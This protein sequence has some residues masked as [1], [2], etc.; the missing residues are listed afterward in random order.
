MLSDLQQEMVWDGWIAAE[1]RAT[2]FGALVSTFQNRQRVL[3][4]A[5]LLLSSGATFTLL[6]SVVPPQL[7]WIK[8]LLTVLAAAMS[9]WSLVAKN[10]RSAID[11]ADLHSRWGTLA[12]GYETLW[13]DM[14]GDNAAQT[15]ERL[16]KDEI[17]VSK[18][19]IAMP[20][21]KGM[22][23]SAQKNVVMHHQKHLAA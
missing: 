5:G 1:I 2:Y 16:R 9:L 8:P 23:V 11:A 17:E 20:A 3:V 12:L 13:A 6:T 4:V 19:S 22:L 7:A 18:S 15:L 14:Y 10:E 21:Y